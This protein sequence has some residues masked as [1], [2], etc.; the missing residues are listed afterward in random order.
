MKIIYKYKVVIAIVLPIVFLV[1]IRSFGANHFRNDAKK[2]YE[3]SVVQSNLTTRERLGKLAGEKLTINLDNKNGENS[4]ISGKVLMIPP[5]SILS[6]NI[7]NIIRK[8]KGPVILYSSETAV[9]AKLWMVLSQ[10]GFQKIYIL[11]EDAD[12]E[13]FSFK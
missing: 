4:E 11:T 9:S 10:M 5:D 8:H 12:N 2:W 3:P 7:L 13:V 1:L 6:K